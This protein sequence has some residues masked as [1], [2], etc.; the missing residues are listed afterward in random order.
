VGLLSGG[1]ARAEGSLSGYFGGDSV[2]E[3]THRVAVVMSP[4]WARLTVQRE[5]YNGGEQIDEAIYRIVHSQEVAAV[6]LRT[7][8]SVPGAVWY[9]GQ[10]MEA[11]EAEA[12]YVALTGRGEALPRDPALLY[13]VSPTELGLQVFPCAVG[14]SQ[15]V[16]YE[17]LVP[18]R[19][20]Q[21]KDVIDLGGDGLEG[22]Q[23]NYRVTPARAGDSVTVRD[24]VAG[25][26]AALEVA[27]ATE[28]AKVSLQ[29]QGAAPLSARFASLGLHSGRSLDW[30]ELRA[31]ARISA[32]PKNAWV[33]VIADTSV[34]MG[35]GILNVEAPA[36]EAY[37]SHVPDAHVAVVAFDRVARD[38][39]QGWA[40]PSDAEVAMRRWPSVSRNGSQVDGAL[41]RARELLRAAPAGAAKRVLVLTDAH[42]RRALTQEVLDRALRDTQAVVHVAEVS[43]GAPALSEDDAHPWLNGVRATGGLTW[44]AAV[45]TNDAA[46]RSVFEEWA[47][48]R[49]YTLEQVSVNAV[50]LGFLP[51]PGRLEEGTAWSGS[52]LRDGKAGRLSVRARLW[53]RAVT[54][55]VASQPEEAKVRAALAS[56][57]SEDALSPEEVQELAW[58]GGAV[59][60]YTSYLAVEPGVRPSTAGIERD[61]SLSGVGMGFGGGRGVG[62]SLGAGKAS[63]FDPRAWLTEEVRKVRHRCGADGVA[64][65][66]TIETDRQEVLDLPVLQVATQD[67][68]IQGCFLEA[69]W[70]LALPSGFTRDYSGVYVIAL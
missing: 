19:Y 54:L 36:V 4:G 12:K 58:K 69:L 11:G 48:P 38:V 17:L 34:S 68:K 27:L 20:E 59:S 23:V 14:K 7:K 67:A 33:V 60:P 47:R 32:V 30:A 16:E 43:A 42:T 25:S 39:T 49:Y 26:G 63:S 64:V 24:V 1:V 56:A 28:A 65:T 46:T 61:L 10:L 29:S 5:I 66:A 35:D 50:P 21:G 22:T 37:L 9:R 45:E 3:R 55:D 15:W 6:G 31:A 52:G 51:D 41:G 53:G 62:V 2:T 57:F 13:W 44:S 8:S 40:T 18:T 70:E